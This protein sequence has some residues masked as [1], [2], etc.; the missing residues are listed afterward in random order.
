M[1]LSDMDV[2]P[3]M[4]QQEKSID[5][6]AILTNLLYCAYSKKQVNELAS[7]F[8]INN[9]DQLYQ[10]LSQVTIDHGFEKYI[11]MI[12]PNKHNSMDRAFV[13]T[14]YDD[15]WLEIYDANQYCIND[16]IIK[17]C[18][19]SHFPL[20]W[21]QDIYNSEDQKVM[22]NRGKSYGLGS[23]VVFPIHGPHGEFGMMSFATNRRASKRLKT[24][25]IKV[26]PLLS[27][28][29]NYV[30]ELSKNFNESLLTNNVSLT[31]KEREII[32][33]YTAGKT[34]WE[35]SK[36]LG[37]VESTVNFHL[38]NIRNKFDASSTQ[39][40]VVRALRIGLIQ[41]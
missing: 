9:L 12:L 15:K 4:K 30:F 35:I 27:V 18:Y 37:C 41:I 3:E 10:A 21:H 17:H 14:N 16:P 29:V 1:A 5:A 19:E 40:A 28:F 13:L 31:P 38:S 39:L 36:I 8:G 23:G 25:I 33:W 20:F 34:S 7:V 26:I 6:E 22:Y 24:D 11:F 2:A 32:N